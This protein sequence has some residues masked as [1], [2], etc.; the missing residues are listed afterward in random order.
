[1]GVVQWLVPR[2]TMVECK[3]SDGTGTTLSYA[4]PYCWALTLLPQAPDSNEVIVWVASSG[5]HK[6]YSAC[7]V[8]A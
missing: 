7:A 6:G 4:Y 8:F 3:E 5:S 1:M 2:V